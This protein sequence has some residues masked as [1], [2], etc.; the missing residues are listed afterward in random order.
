MVVRSVDGLKT[1][2]SHTVDR[3]TA[4]CVHHREAVEDAEGAHAESLTFVV[5][6]FKEK[7]FF[8]LRQKRK[9][10]FSKVKSQELKNVH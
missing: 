4:W 10:D 1:I 9:S 5:M 3:Q 6:D 2:K 8:F 7:G